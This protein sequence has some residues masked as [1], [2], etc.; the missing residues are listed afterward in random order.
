MILDILD[1]QQL[2][3]LIIPS[4]ATGPHKAIHLA[5]TGFTPFPSLI[6]S[7]YTILAQLRLARVQA[8]RRGEVLT[9]GH[10]YP[11]DVQLVH[12]AAHE[13]VT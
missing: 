12:K 5:T 7:T 11:L 2:Q 8:T 10:R 6:N 4:S 9:I 1:C 3:I 13:G